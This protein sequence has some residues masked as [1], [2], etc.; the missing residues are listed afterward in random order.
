MTGVVLA[1]HIIATVRG[2]LYLPEGRI[3]IRHDLVLQIQ[4]GQAESAEL[5]NK[6][7]IYLSAL[8][9]QENVQFPDTP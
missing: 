9:F 3:S 6:A 2:P 4:Y 5:K 7:P 8:Q 1:F